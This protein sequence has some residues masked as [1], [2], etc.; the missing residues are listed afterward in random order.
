MKNK[1]RL[2]SMFAV[3]MILSMLVNP[4]YASAQAQASAT[5][6]GTASGTGAATGSSSPTM[7]FDTTPPTTDPAGNPISSN[8][9]P[10]GAP[11]TTLRDSTS[12]AMAGLDPDL[13][14]P[15]GDNF[16]MCDGPNPAEYDP[17][18]FVNS[19]FMSESTSTVYNSH[20]TAYDWRT[21]PKVMTAG[22]LK[23]TTAVD[24]S[25][26]TK[27][28][29]TGASGYQQVLTAVL[30][31]S[32]DNSTY[33]LQLVVEDYNGGKPGTYIIALPGTVGTAIA[34]G[35]KSRT[36]GIAGIKMPCLTRNASCSQVE[37][38]QWFNEQDYKSY[39]QMVACRGRVAILV[40]QTLYDYQLT[41]SSNGY[42][43]D[44]ERYRTFN[45]PSLATGDTPMI[46][47]K[48]GDV[49]ND[50]LQDLIITLSNAQ[51]TAGTTLLLYNWEQDQQDQSTESTFWPIYTAAITDAKAAAAAVGNVTGS[52]NAV[53]VS[54]YTANNTLAFMYATYSAQ[55]GGFS[56]ATFS[57]QSNVSYAQDANVQKGDLPD[58]TCV[59]FGDP[60]SQYVFYDGSI[61]QYDQGELMSISPSAVA[62]S[63]GES[64][65]LDANASAATANDPLVYFDV[66]VGNIYPFNGQPGGQQLA[67]LAEDENYGDVVNICWYYMNNSSQISVAK[68]GDIFC[69]A[70]NSWYNGDNIKSSYFQYP[71]LSGADVKGVLYSLSY[72]GSSFAMSN[73]KVVAVL[74]ASPYYQELESEYGSGWGNEATEY[75]TS[76][77]QEQES[78]QGVNVSVGATIGFDYEVEGGLF[79]STKLAEFEGEVNVTAELTKEWSQT[80]SVTTEQSFSSVGDDMVVVTS[81]P[82]EIYTYHVNDPGQADN[83]TDV[84]VPVPY[85]PQ[86]IMMGLDDYNQAVAEMNAAEPSGDTVAVAVPASALLN[87]TVGDPRTY[88][89]SLNGFPTYGPTGPS[90]SFKAGA[91][92]SGSI[93]TAGDFVNAGSGNGLA[94][95]SIEYETTTASSF[96]KAVNVDASFTVT[97]MSFV[98]GV[99]AG[100]GYN[101]G[102]TTSVGSGTEFSG[103]VV[104][105]PPQEGNYDFEWELVC[106]KAYLTPDEECYVVNYLVNPLGDIPAPPPGDLQLITYNGTSATI[107][108]DSEAAS[109]IYKYLIYRSSS[110]NVDTTKPYATV[111]PKSGSFQAYTD[112]N[113]LDGHQYYYEVVAE[114]SNP[115]LGYSKPTTPLAVPQLITG[116]TIK[117][118]PILSYNEG[119]TLDLS[120][121]VITATYTDNTTTDLSF[122]DL[123]QRGMSFS[124]PAGTVLSPEDNGLS[125]YI[126]DPMTQDVVVTDPLK[127]TS[128]AL[129]ALVIT[130]SFT[131]GSTN[132]A[133]SLVANEAL[134]AQIGITNN[135]SAPQSVIAVVALFDPNGTMTNVA[136]ATRTI[137]VGATAKFGEGGF[138]LPSPIA[139]YVAKAFVLE[140]T[141]FSS[142]SL[143]PL[144]SIA[145]I[146]P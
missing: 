79:I 142:S 53:L 20:G 108:W 106:Y 140:G 124:I 114:T 35:S 125:I 55:T 2:A 5:A 41:Y 61:F 12:I 136:Y 111:V 4:L 133:A 70:Q 18:R 16:I 66:A 123:L 54:Y 76:T 116:F 130:T 78:T 8:M 43:A 38:T 68:S 102:F 129:S 145:Q 25:G 82:Y 59:S 15:N 110:E 144:S 1:K 63:D 77:T 126:T 101:S 36:G 92:D 88:P 52:G 51:G 33:E 31:P 83:G 131:V 89:Q 87:H 90:S 117:T 94:E 100:A 9:N 44:L 104:N 17:T 74:G 105:L 24:T 120:S 73:P 47:L 115:G 134:T 22:D 64:N 29:L 58:L 69:T 119:D 138:T 45:F 62:V 121:L 71:A 13:Q 128:V 28:D 60:N 7:A 32:G 6:S 132:N 118:Q 30:V 146:C 40:N 34:S 86:L 23:G 50:G 127:V 10:F 113:L 21:L 57:Q 37:G 96:D 135:Q 80:A 3:A 143:M 109:N 72:V 49:E 84:R 112:S 42:S 65:Y 97:V 122:N 141:Q 81:I 137:G 95:Q 93:V 26:T 103:S 11:S 67:V 14:S 75:G 27:V 39:F 48:A 91:L 19:Q 85:A 99:N 56:R 98:A 107:S 46:D 139:G